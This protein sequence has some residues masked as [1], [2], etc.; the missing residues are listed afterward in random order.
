MSHTHKRYHVVNVREGS[1]LEIYVSPLSG[2]LT[3]KF[4]PYREASR[5]NRAQAQ[6]ACTVLAFIEGSVSN[7]SIEEAG[8]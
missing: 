6:A 8:A 5:L 1:A 4:G 7:L 2:K 3:F